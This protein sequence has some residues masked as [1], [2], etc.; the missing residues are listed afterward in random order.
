FPLPHN[1][2]VNEFIMTIGDRRIRGIIREREEA[3]KI[4]AAAR[5]QGLVA[6]LLTEERPNIFTHSVAN[7]EPG[8]E[9]DVNI[10]YFHTLDYVDGW[11]EFVFPMAVG[12]RDNSP[13]Q[14]NGIGAVPRGASGDSGQ[15]TE[16]EYLRP[17]EKSRHDVSLKVD[18]NAG[19]VIED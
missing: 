17:G 8:K 9:I 2:A 4:Y 19:V 10:K 3:Q 1:A 14:T 18:V 12:P 16:I 7:I 15:P 6:A 13:S 5:S 11:Y